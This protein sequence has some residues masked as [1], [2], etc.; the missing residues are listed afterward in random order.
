MGGGRGRRGRGNSLNY[1]FKTYTEDRVYVT[2]ML[3]INS[4]E[5]RGQS[6]GIVLKVTNYTHLY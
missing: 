1:R 5:S 3:K 6:R 4:I 2:Q